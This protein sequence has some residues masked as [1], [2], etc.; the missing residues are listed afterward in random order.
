MTETESED[1]TEKTVPE[2]SCSMPCSPLTG[3]EKMGRA[4][5]FKTAMGAVAI[6]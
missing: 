3:E 2:S 1:K 4:Q 6:C 5:F